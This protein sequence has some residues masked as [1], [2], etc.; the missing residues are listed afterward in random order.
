MYTLARYTLVWYNE[1]MESMSFKDKA[2]EKFYIEGKLPKN[3]KWGN[4]KKIALRKL[5][6]ICYAE[7][8]EDL[9]SPPNNRLEELKGNLQ[10][11]HSIRI[12]DQWRIIFK[13]TTSGVKNIDIVDYHK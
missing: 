6:M 3:A 12:N 1:F 5:D 11:L 2:I 7:K 10:G 9:R 4:I 8:L 13:W